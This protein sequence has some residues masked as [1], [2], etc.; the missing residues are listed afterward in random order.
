MLMHEG[1]K[2]VDFLKPQAFKSQSRTAGAQEK[3]YTVSP[4]IDLLRAGFKV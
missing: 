4:V 1:R 3:G 2:R